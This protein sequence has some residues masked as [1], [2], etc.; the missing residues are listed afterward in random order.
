MGMP[1]HLRQPCVPDTRNDALIDEC[2]THETRLVDPAESLDDRSEIRVGREQIGAELPHRTG[3]EGED[4]PVP[5]GRLPL[6]AAKDEPRRTD[7][8][9]FVLPADAPA[10]VH[11]EVAADDDTAVET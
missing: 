8:S 10:T 5:L 7:Q 4:R 11:A 9:P 2:F 6:A 3:I 1:E